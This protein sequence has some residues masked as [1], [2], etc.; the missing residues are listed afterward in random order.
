MDL[1][2][3]EIM[4]KKSSLSRVLPLLLLAAALATGRVALYLINPIALGGGSD[5]YT[6][7][8]SHKKNPSFPSAAGKGRAAYPDTALASGD[9]S[10]PV[11]FDIDGLWTTST[12]DSWGRADNL[13]W[14][15]GTPYIANLSP[16]NGLVSLKLDVVFLDK[17]T[18]ETVSLPLVTFSETSDYATTVS[19][20][21]S[22][23]AASAYTGSLS[24]AWQDGA[25]YSGTFSAPPNGTYDY[26]KV[27][28]PEDTWIM[29]IIYSYSCTEA[30]T[31]S[32]EQP[33]V[34]SDSGEAATE[35]TSL[36]PIS[37]PS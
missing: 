9:T 15:T 7:T 19:G 32:S 12:D 24:T 3:N 25:T 37:I 11:Y 14:E 35:A 8:L 31:G 5:N 27:N 20:S 34:A 22:F 6:L 16:L 13:S 21:G 33:G 17:T 2:H 10:Y 1:F 23:G 26:V 28:F 30:A 29:S 36:V 4:K 18:S